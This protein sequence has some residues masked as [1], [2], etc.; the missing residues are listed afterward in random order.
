MVWQQ[1][2]QSAKKRQLQCHVPSWKLVVWVSFSPWKVA[3]NCANWMRS[4][5]CAYCLALA[6]FPIMLECIGVPPLSCP[7]ACLMRGR[8]VH[9]AGRDVATRERQV[10][11]LLVGRQPPQL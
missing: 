4:G 3:S 10:H 5:S 6:I 8:S 7:A 2:P 11:A 1:V 9:H